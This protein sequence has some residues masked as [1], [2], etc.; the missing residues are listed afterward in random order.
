MTRL[1]RIRIGGVVRV[2]ISIRVCAWRPVVPG[3]EGL[4]VVSRENATNPEGDL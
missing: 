1:L 3:S 2:L 4:V